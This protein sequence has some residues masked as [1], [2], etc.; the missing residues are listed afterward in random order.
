MAGL[1]CI[2]FAVVS[3]HKISKSVCLCETHTHTHR[4]TT[5]ICS[6]YRCNSCTIKENI[7]VYINLSGN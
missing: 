2:E 5:M 6:I 7:P 4:L 1:K 3:I